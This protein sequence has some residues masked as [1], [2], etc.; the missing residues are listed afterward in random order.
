MNIE[1]NERFQSSA[2]EIAYGAIG[3]GPDLVL[4]HGTP[5]HSIIWQGVVAQLAQHFRCH[6]LD[7]PGYGQSAKYDGQ[8]VRLRSFARVLNE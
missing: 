5:A 1:L 3:E 2:G 8:D 4:V 7:L 6:L